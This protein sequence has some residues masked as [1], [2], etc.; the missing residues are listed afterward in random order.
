MSLIKKIEAIDHA[1]TVAEL[2]VLLNTGKTAIYDMARRYAIPHYRVAGLRFD[3]QEL[4]DWL[5]GRSIKPPGDRG[6]TR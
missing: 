1:V 4:A 5:R 2:S 6:R 3:P